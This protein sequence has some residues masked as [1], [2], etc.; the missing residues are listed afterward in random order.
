MLSSPNASMPVDK[1]GLIVVPCLVDETKTAGGGAAQAVL[2][3]VD[4]I[5]RENVLYLEL[6]PGD[7]HEQLI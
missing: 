4:A 3:S 7:V 2:H 5:M 1:I 6:C